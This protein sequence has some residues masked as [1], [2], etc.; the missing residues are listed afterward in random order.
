M[1]FPRAFLAATIFSLLGALP[2]QAARFEALGKTQWRY[3]GIVQAI[4]RDR[5]LDRVVL[6][7]PDLQS[8]IVEADNFFVNNGV[9]SDL[10]PLRWTNPLD[11]TV[12]VSLVF[13]YDLVLYFGSNGLWDDP[14][15]GVYDVTMEAGLEATRDDALTEALGALTIDRI[16]DCPS[17]ACVNRYRSS[18]LYPG[19]FDSIV[20]MDFILGPLESTEITLRPFVSVSAA[21][22]SATTTPVPLPGSVP[23]MLTGF[24]ALSA[25]AQRRRLTAASQRPIET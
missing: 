25:C 23:L 1:Y 6:D 13:R 4:V 20:Y 9:A 5:P 10:I 22:A 8:G 7:G 19:G 2:V 3:D 16:L 24:A 21:P 17:P 14:Q 12:F 15:P 18:S 11:D